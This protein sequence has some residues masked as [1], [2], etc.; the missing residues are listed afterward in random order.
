MPAGRNDNVISFH[1]SDW[2]AWAPGLEDRTAWEAWA[3]SPWLP[4]GDQTPALAEVP[5]M[6]RR[7]IERL[8]RMAM[9]AALWCGEARAE[10]V[11]VVFSSR[12]GDVQRSLALMQQQARGEPMSPAGFSL[13]VH[14]A[15]AAMH[16]IALGLR[17]NYTALAAARACAENALVEAVGL[18][19][20]GADEVQVVL[21]DASLPDAY[22]PF[23]DEPDPF[24]AWSCRV[25]ST[26]A[27]AKI[28]LGWRD[29]DAETCDPE[30]LPASLGALRFLLSD[31]PLRVH[32]ADRT[33][34]EWRRR[35]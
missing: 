34:W 15:V 2:A 5:A 14:N 23:L 1:L 10:G 8:G 32:V 12:H 20:D 25:R 26:G 21:Y 29:A 4:H 33:R 6:Q 7:R 18:L 3:R 17:G 16:S 22:A 31:A 30:L 24:H 11:P 9:Q 13:S 27:G 28:S 19:A 35:G